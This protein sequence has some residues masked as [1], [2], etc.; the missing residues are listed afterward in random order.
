MKW[1]CFLFVCGLYLNFINCY[2]RFFLYRRVGE[3]NGDF[4]IYYVLLIL[5]FFYNKLFEL[6]I[7]F[8]YICVENRFR[9][10]ILIIK[11]FVI[12]C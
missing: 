7:D 8:I 6:V 9:V 3:I 4:L 11:K 2:F 12:F 1:I 5:K 10:S